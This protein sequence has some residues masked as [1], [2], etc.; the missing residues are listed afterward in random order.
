MLTIF[1]A[2]PY[3]LQSGPIKSTLPRTME[4]VDQGYGFIL[5]KTNL[6]QLSL[7][8]GTSKVVIK[9]DSIHDRS[10]IM[11]DQVSLTYGTTRRASYC[12]IILP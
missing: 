8:I 9:V 10:V 7:D 4:D 1:E 5:Y 3:L 2:L 12:A 6:K 11:I